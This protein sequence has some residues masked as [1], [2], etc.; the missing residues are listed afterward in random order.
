MLHTGQFLISIP[1]QAHNADRCYF[2]V[3]W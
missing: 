2:I 1:L 3:C